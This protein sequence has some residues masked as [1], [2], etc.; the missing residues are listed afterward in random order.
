MEFADVLRDGKQRLDDRPGALGVV[1]TPRLA[2]VL[3]FRNRHT[4]V[5]WER[6]HVASVFATQP[7]APPRTP[8]DDAQSFVLADRHQFPFWAPAEDIVLWL[9]THVGFPSHV[10]TEIDRFLEL[11]PSVIAIT[12][13][14]YFAVLHQPVKS[15]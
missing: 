5:S 14:P 11:P 9:Q 15:A 7:P 4:A 8:G 1:V 12:E 6:R 10:P 2:P 3:V 13:V